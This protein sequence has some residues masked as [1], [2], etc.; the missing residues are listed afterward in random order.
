MDKIANIIIRDVFYVMEFVPLMIH[1]QGTEF[2]NQLEKEIYKE[3]GI[4]IRLTSTDHSSSN[5][6]P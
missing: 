1:D 5:M 6:V 3:I 2:I 4:T